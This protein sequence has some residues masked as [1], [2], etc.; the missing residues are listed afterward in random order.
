MM[1]FPAA[2]VFIICLIALVVCKQDKAPPTNYMYAL[3]FTL[4]TAY[5]VSYLAAQYKA[6]TIL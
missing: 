2:I 5:M 4:A 1:V 3:F 6:Y